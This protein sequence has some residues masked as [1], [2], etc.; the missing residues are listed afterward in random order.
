M[1]FSVILILLI[2]AILIG[3]YAAA[4]TVSRRVDRTEAA[5][6]R[7]QALLAEMGG[8]VAAQAEE[9]ASL[10]R[11]IWALRG[12]T[13]DDAAYGAFPE[14][15]PTP[16]EAAPEA[17]TGGPAGPAREGLGARVGGWMR[18]GAMERQFGAVL[19]VWIGGI[20]LAF[21]GFFLVKYSIENDLV[22]PELRII[23]GGLLGFALI[24]A[25]R[26]VSSRAGIANGERIAQSLAGA[27]IA[28]LYVSAY[29]ATA[30]YGLLAPAAGFAAM[31]AVTGAAVILALRHGPAIA[32]LG[33][34]GGFLTPALIQ[35]DAPSAPLLFIYLGLVFVGLMV[36][37]RRRGW[38]LLALPAV[39]L[40]GFWVLAWLFSDAFRPDETLWA[41]LFLLAV[42]G[43]I[44]TATRERYTAEMAEIT[45]WRDLL[46]L[47]HRALILNTLSLAGAL[48]LMAALGSYAA[49]GAQDWAL[50]ALLAIATVALAVFDPR[51]YGFAPWAA[52]AINV[53][54][55][56]GWEPGATREIATAIAAFGALFTLAGLLL[57]RGAAYPLLWAALSAS[58]ALG[59]YLLAYFRVEEARPA[60][61][62]A[63]PPHPIDVTPNTQPVEPLVEAARDT[64]SA[65]P[66]LW[67][68]VAMALALI[69]FGA[70]LRAARAMP[71]EP[72]KERVLAVFALAT[73]AFVALALTV[74][75]ERE[76]LS[77]A[78]A[79]ELAAV[80]WI[81]GRTQI[82]SLRLI[83]ILLL[84]AFAYLLIPQILLLVQ[85]SV[86]SLLDIRLD[87]QETIP[88][89]DYPLFQL[90]LPAG[91][92]LT[93]AALLR[94]ERDDGL[95]RGLE[96]GSVALLALWGYYAA[97]KLFHPGENVLYAT[98]G[99]LERGVITNLLFLYGL[100]WLAAGRR[101]GRAAFTAS[102]LL[103]IGIALFRIVY[104]DLFLKNPLWFPDAVPGP[105]PFDALAITFGLPILWCW[106]AA[107]EIGALEGRWAGL[108]S[109]WL[110]GLMLLFGFAWLNLTIRKAYQGP[111]LDG[112][113]IGDAELYSYSAAWLVFGLA[114]LFLGAL[115][116]SQ[117]LRF[118]SL[119]VM[120]AT[121]SKVFLVDA[122]SLTG[123]YR[124]FSFLALG[125]SLIG[126]SWF[127]SRFVFGGSAG[128]EAERRPAE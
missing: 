105:A 60:P 80:A 113:A 66:H 35:S 37:I 13:P 97:S 59:Y 25:A 70:A 50:L 41:G 106:L 86:Y 78:I 45:G 11:E 40:A 56:A 29:A 108:L 101:L 31:A 58:A 8:T 46:S 77:V 73:A 72:V 44:V 114:L 63:P 82:G 93:A 125:L 43:T 103:L 111:L 32:L 94:R 16:S 62:A 117:M 67:G 127:Y 5:A 65:L 69:F 7:A 79:A 118:A 9:I 19:P 23:L 104:F 100:F 18:G 15:P 102:G 121:V 30:L 110:P 36:V 119:A 33:L 1:E 34:L 124:V 17:V 38:W 89:V 21:A 75:L 49:F 123:L 84:A 48:A 76:F 47:R 120:L 64:A 27:G 126:L 92:F 85:L 24:A 74:E 98:A 61:P 96:G 26:F 88:I 95:V 4:W 116:G 28:V 3:P 10:R 39:I 122:G 54:M 68:V 12:V 71:A 51:L 20:A 87:W 91:L 2:L 128:G 57:H 53:V 14:P 42:A 55:L 22:G 107:Q 6:R 115:R 90:A 83:A 99:F 52:M 81:A 112:A 109:R